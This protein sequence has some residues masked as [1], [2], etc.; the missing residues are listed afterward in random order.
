MDKA[1]QTAAA[2][3]EDQVARQSYA[4]ILIRV[5]VHDG[6]VRQVE[7]QVTEKLRGEK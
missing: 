1:I 4:E 2:W 3:L 5:T 7:R 6:Q